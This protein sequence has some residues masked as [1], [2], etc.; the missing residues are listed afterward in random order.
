MPAVASNCTLFDALWSLA[1]VVQFEKGFRQEHLTIVREIR[2]RAIIKTEDYLSGTYESLNQELTSGSFFC[3]CLT[4]SW[5]MVLVQQA[6][7]HISSSII[8]SCD[9]DFSDSIS[10]HLVKTVENPSLTLSKYTH[11]W[12]EGTTNLLQYFLNSSNNC[13]S[14]LYA[15]IHAILGLATHSALC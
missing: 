11:S 7:E 10:L 9:W 15:D 5:Q 1:Q 4:K 14:C 12:G 13:T 6:W 3:S 2:T 8:L